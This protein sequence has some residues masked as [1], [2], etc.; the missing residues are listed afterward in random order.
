[1]VKERYQS[2]STVQFEPFTFQL[3]GDTLSLEVE[4]EGMELDCGWK[5]VPMHPPTVSH[6]L[7]L[8]TKLENHSRLIPSATGGQARTGLLQPRQVCARL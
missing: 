4:K 3:E 7:P 6:L 5:F 1:M 8:V 2:L